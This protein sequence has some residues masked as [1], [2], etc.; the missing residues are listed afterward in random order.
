MNR[1]IAILGCGWLGLP[2]AKHFIKQGFPSK[3]ST[4]SAKKLAELDQVGIAPYLI[5]LSET[6]IKGDIDGFLKDVEVLVIN[7][8]PRLRSGQGENYVKKMQLLHRAIG[9]SRVKKVIF[10]S[11]TSV[12][13]DVE[14]EVTEKTPPHPITESGKQ[15]LACE[16]LF[17]KDRRLQTT[18]VRF[19]GL[20]GPKRHP[21]TL[22]SKRT[23]LTNGHHPVNLIHLNDCVRILHEIIANN[24]WNETLNA[25]HPEHPTKEE[26][27]IKEAKK[28]G[29]QRPEYKGNNSKKGKIVS[30]DT[31]INV[32]G[33]T[34][35]T[36]L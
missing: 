25:V 3:G 14:G 28:R 31:L 20:I 5:E 8:P 4:T 22:L 15:L 30:S 9:A 7:V 24:W 1:S 16:N 27:Y 35:S 13:G 32:K 11:S 36:T 33:F 23:G 10:A 29:V 34:F 12:Y 19:G 18:I 26:Y 21:V 6:G 2:L 17:R